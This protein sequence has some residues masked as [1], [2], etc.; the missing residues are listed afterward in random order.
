MLPCKRDIRDIR[1]IVPLFPCP[2]TDKRDTTLRSVP[3][4]LRMYRLALSRSM[5]RCSVS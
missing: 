3:F 2:E 5:L 1:D 4:V